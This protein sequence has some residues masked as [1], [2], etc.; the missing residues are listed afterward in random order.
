MGRTL[1]MAWRNLWRNWRRTVIALIAV[2][3]GLTLLLLFDGFIY[4][5]DQAIFGNAVKLYGGNI[6]VHAPGFREKARRLPL[7]PLADGDAVV[8]AA[9]ARP[10]VAMAG[11][12]TDQVQP[13]VLAAAKRIHTGGLVTNR[14]GSFAV[15]IT[16]VEPEIEQALSIQA[17][18]VVDGRYLLPDDGDAVFIGLGLAKMMDV[19]VG[20]RVTLIGRSTDESMRQRSMTIVGIYSLGMEEAERGSVFIT[21]EE[22]QTLYNLRGQVTEVAITLAN[23]GQENQII[24][25]LQKSLPGYEIDSWQTLRP[26]ITQTLSAK[27]TYTTM[28]GFIIIIIA[29]IGILNIQLMAV[30]ERTREMGVLAALGMK[31]G[32]ITN[33]FLLEGTLIGVVGAVIG[34]LAGAGVVGLIGSVGLDLSFISGMGEITALMGSRLYPSVGLADTINRG[35]TVIVIVALASL[36]PAWQASR[37]EPAEALHHI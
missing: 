14:E 1:T 31:G 11:V 5:S 10:T 32:Q 15:D 26:E 6:Q 2:V 16:G 13:D 36:Y 4:G 20:D 34:C 7:L 27:L 17:E 3:L 33:L 35:L 18:N 8:A 12:G 28:F 21:L 23:V 30:F 22:A 37:K 29:S 25:D 9:L 19:G 24:A